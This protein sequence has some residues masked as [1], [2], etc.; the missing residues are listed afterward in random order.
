MSGLSPSPGWEVRLAPFRSLFTQPG[1]RLFCA[2]VLTLAHTDGRL[3][4]TSVALSGLLDRHFTRFYG[5][6]KQGAWSLS[7]V[8]QRLF[9]ECLALCLGEDGRLLQAIDD[10]VCPKYGRKFESLGLHHDPMNRQHPR[11]LSRGHGFV[12]LALLGPC[13]KDHFVALFVGCALYVQKSVRQAQNEA[14]E[15]AGQAILAFATKLELAVGLLLDLPIPPGVMVIVVC[16]GAYAK[17][18]F[19][20]PVCASGR[21]ALSRLR[22]D[23]VFYDLPPARRKQPDGKYPPGAPRK[24]GKKH[25]ASEWAASLGTWREVTLRLYGK[26]VTLQVKSRVVIQ[27]TFGVRI[28]LVAVQWGERPRI[29]LFC[30]DTTMSA[31]A[32]VRAYCA[33]F[34]I[35]TGFR[36]A[37][38]SFGMSTYQVR[39]EKSILRLVHLCLWAQTFLRLVYWNQKPQPIYGDW[40]KPLGYL[41]LAQQKRLSQAA[42]RVSAG[43]YASVFNA[44]FQGAEAVAA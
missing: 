14:A 19:V 24:Y 2:F 21:Q 1:F 7:A 39:N 15:Q 11:Q 43:S 26:Q 29:F 37:K 25:K 12:G 44:E 16:D 3:W 34:A 33:R 9:A 6:L 30:T 10:T 41:T 22:S 5:F 4:V 17:K 31:E 35:E 23:A 36:D 18:A 42:C 13:L 32:I 28:R 20:Q 38:Q 27:R 40:R 8:R